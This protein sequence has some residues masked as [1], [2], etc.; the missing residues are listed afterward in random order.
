MC[1]ALMNT[2]H[3]PILS[4]AKV[5]TGLRTVMQDAPSPPSRRM[6]ARAWIT[7][8]QPDHRRLGVPG[9]EILHEHRSQRLAASASGAPGRSHGRLVRDSRNGRSRPPTREVTVRWI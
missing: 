8:S 2:G 9:I 4:A 5:A 3:L 1:T 7:Q 6:E